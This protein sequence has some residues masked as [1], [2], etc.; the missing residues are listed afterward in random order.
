MAGASRDLF[1]GAGA[2]LLPDWAQTMLGRGPLRRARDRTAAATL[3]AIAPLFRDALTDGVAPRACN[4]VGVAAESLRQW[5]AA[6][7]DR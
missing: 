7:V 2:A 1:L 5:P 4:R 6:K 3:R